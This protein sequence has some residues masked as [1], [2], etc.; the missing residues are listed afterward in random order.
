MISIALGGGYPRFELRHMK[1]IKTN[2][3]AIIIIGLSS[4]VAMGWFGE[5]LWTVVLPGRW[6][7]NEAFLLWT[8]GLSAAV[9]VIS[10]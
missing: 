7:G 5:A 2:P 4:G 3:F 10:A 6:D 8:F 9:G 1:T